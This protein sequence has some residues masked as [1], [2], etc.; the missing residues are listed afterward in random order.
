MNEGDPRYTLKP[1]PYSSHSVILRW[2]SDGRGRRLLDV[3]AADGFLSRRLTDQGWRVTAIEADPDL[4][5]AGASSCERMIITDLNRE[6][7]PLG[8]SFDVIV[9]GDVLEHLTQPLTVLVELVQSLA[10]DG[11]AVI[12]IPNVAHLW[13]RLS[14]LLGRFEYANRGILDRGHLRFFTDSSLRGL[15]TAA[16]LTIVRRATTP[17]PLHQVLAPRWH[18]AALD[19]V[20][21]VSALGA[22]M[23]P[24]LLGY[25]FVVLA[26]R[27]SR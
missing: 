15:V 23:L 1:D 21:A 3:G 19:T 26:Q 27:T 11:H 14:L 13:V 20:Q 6:V 4:A 10:R 24:R 5:R 22:R 17:V 25:Q 2:L 16:G 7:P 18:N 9:L 8:G 12:S